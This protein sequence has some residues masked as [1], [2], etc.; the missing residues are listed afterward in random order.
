MVEID[1]GNGITTRYGHLSKVLVKEGDVVSEGDLIALSGSTGR[2]TGPHLHY[3]VRRNGTAVDP[4]RFLN[5]G[6]KL[7]SYI[8]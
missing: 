5:A 3:E 2:S 4:M 1:H 7:T 8:Q 6:L